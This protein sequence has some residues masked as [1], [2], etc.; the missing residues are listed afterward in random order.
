MKRCKF[1]L[2]RRPK[3]DRTVDPDVALVDYDH[4]VWGQWYHGTP[5][6]IMPGLTCS[7]CDRRAIGGRGTRLSC[8]RWQCYVKFRQMEFRNWWY[9]IR[10]PSKAYIDAQE[11]ILRLN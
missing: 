4:G 9:N 6:T 2:S 1:V 3:F 10:P 11:A 7:T 5:C 8:G